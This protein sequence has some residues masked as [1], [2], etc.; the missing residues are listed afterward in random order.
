[1][2]HA[3]RLQ[4]K[5]IQTGNCDKY[6]KIT[7][8]GTGCFNIQPV[9]VTVNTTPAVNVTTAD[10]SICIGSSLNLNSTLTPSSTNVPVTFSNTTDLPIPDNNTQVN[11]NI[12]VSGINSQTAGV[13]PIVSVLVNFTH[14]WDADL[15]IYLKCPDGTLIQLSTGNGGSGDNYTNTYFVPTG[16]GI[17][18]GTAPFSGNFSP[19]QA[20]SLL[21]ACTINGVWSLVVSD[22]T[23]G[24]SGIL[25][26]WSITFNNYTPGPTFIWSPTN[27]MTNSTTLTLTV[28]P[29]TTTSYTLTGTSPSGGYTASDI[30]NITV[31]PL[32]TVIAG[33]DQSVCVGGNIV[34]A[35][36]IGGSATSGTWSASS[37]S[38]SSA[39]DPGATYTPTI[40]SGTVTLT[41]TTNAPAPCGAVNDQVVITVNPL[42]TINGTLA[43]P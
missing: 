21:N 42:P 30:V 6:I 23:T 5:G 16:T 11:S 36:T 38:F 18:A 15:D 4:F 1:M 35:G 3:V 37:G 13:L 24:D 22:N 8:P 9:T 33:T 34:L 7:N 17:T 19:E 41:L 29:A 32:P 43:I 20:F 40:T 14:T 25:L 31:V 27:A 28:S 2:Q 39:T 12:T 26:D 10:Q